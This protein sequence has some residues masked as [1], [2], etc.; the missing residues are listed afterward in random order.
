MSSVTFLQVA[1]KKGAGWEPER[2]KAERKAV[3]VSRV[4]GLSRSF[5][6]QEGK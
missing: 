6:Q 3:S 2:G 1:S 5:G 4:T